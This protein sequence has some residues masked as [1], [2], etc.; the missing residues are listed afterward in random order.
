MTLI[1]SLSSILYNSLNSA[2]FKNF[3]YEYMIS[4]HGGPVIKALDMVDWN[5][6]FFGIQVPKVD[7]Y[8]DT[9]V[10]EKCELN[11]SQMRRI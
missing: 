6:W 4:Y 11:Q 9:T 7:F 2:D 3:L 10:L 1:S 5:A 8:F